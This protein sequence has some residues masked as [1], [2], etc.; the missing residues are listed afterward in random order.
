MKVRVDEMTELRGE[1]G[2]NTIEANERAKKKKNSKFFTFHNNLVVSK[3]MNENF[4]Q[5]TSKG[6]KSA[7]NSKTKTSCRNKLKQL[8]VLALRTKPSELD[9]NGSL[10]EAVEMLGYES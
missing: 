4:L 3:Y 10:V 6:R 2:H 7:A 5:S 1:E 8:M 9:L